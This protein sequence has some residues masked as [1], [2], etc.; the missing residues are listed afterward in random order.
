MEF[1]VLDREAMFSASNCAEKVWALFGTNDVDEIA[2]RVGVKITEE[3]WQP[4]TFGEYHR[5]TK[6]IV[7]NTN[8]HET[9]EKIVAHELGHFFWQAFSLENSD[10]KQ[11]EESFCNEFAARI[12]N[13]R[14]ASK[15]LCRE[16]EE[17]ADCA[18]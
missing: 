7:I 11:D 10:G 13:D 1:E 9:R 5:K 18:T 14:I 2:A 15:D 3:S 4:V 12:V 16:P 8:A 6:L 17:G